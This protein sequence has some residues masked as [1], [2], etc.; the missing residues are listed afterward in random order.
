MELT[1]KNICIL[2]SALAVS[3]SL[4]VGFSSTE[5]SNNQR[6]F[7]EEMPN[8]EYTIAFS[9]S[10]NKLDVNDGVSSAFTARGSDIRVAHHGLSSNNYW[11][12]ISNG[13]YFQNVDPING[14]KYIRI[15]YLDNENV[16]LNVS[17]GWDDNMIIQSELSSSQVYAFNNSSS[18]GV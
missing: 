8:A 17:Y 3:L 9:S 14:L 11:R 16:K 18:V 2:F 4:A 15:D 6:V 12:R 13:G 5:K 10:L 1:K 7:G